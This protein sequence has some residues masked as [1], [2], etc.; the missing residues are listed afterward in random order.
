LPYAVGFFLNR[1]DPMVIRIIQDLRELG[2][3][4]TTHTVA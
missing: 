3:A 1:R 4:A 2:G